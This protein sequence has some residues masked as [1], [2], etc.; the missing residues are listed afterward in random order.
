LTN[1]WRECPSPSYSLDS[2]LPGLDGDS[3]EDQDAVFLR[4]IGVQV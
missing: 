1:C 3:Y 4:S 2:V